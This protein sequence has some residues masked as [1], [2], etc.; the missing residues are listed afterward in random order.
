MEKKRSKKKHDSNRTTRWKTTFSSTIALRCTGPGGRSAA[1]QL[2][3]G[4]LG[5]ENTTAR[6]SC[7]SL[8]K[9]QSVYEPF[10][11][12][13][14]S[15]APA[16]DKQRVSFLLSFRFPGNGID[17]GRIKHYQGKRCAS[18]LVWVELGLGA[19]FSILFHL[20]GARRSLFSVNLKIA[21]SLW[22]KDEL[23]VLI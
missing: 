8:P 10:P 4:F 18:A 11:P 9:T 5:P 3:V 17:T 21:I 13:S 1:W 23:S 19:I 22:A 2:E 15:I 20:E 12:Y 7:P 6:R 14:Q 16:H